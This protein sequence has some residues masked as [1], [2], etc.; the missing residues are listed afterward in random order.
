MININLLDWREKRR[1]IENNKLGAFIVLSILCGIFISLLAE[2]TIKEMI[3]SYQ[4][5]VKYLSSEISAVE[6]KISQIQDLETQKNT[7]LDRRKMIESLQDSRSFM[8]KIFDNLPRIIPPGLVLNE[9][10]RKGDLLT[11]IG[12]A[13]NNEIVTA[14]M[15]NLQR[16]KWVKD[17]K[18]ANLKTS[19]SKNPVAEG[20]LVDFQI[21]I[22][23]LDT[24]AEI[25]APET[26]KTTVGAKGAPG[27]KPGVSP[28]GAA[29]PLG[30][31]GIPSG[32]P[33]PAT[34]PPGGK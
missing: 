31:A 2:F 15:L 27:A 9:M 26:T 24:S 23:L 32:A 4:D 18:L 34:T 19:D 11:L 5:N 21:N 25:P 17:A 8:V 28:P 30:P 13:Y 20:A 6:E 12:T 10:T 14:F 33:S 16:L 3:S 1:Q 29:G 22:T 7:L